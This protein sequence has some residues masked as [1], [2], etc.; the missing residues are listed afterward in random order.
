L[1]PHSEIRIPHSKRVTISRTGMCRAIVG[2]GSAIS[3]WLEAPDEVEL[4]REDVHVWSAALDVGPEFVGACAAI[5]IEDERERAA[6][7]RF[8][9]DRTHFIVARATLRKILA[10]YL[11][12]EPT[13][14]AFAAGAYGKPALATAGQGWLQFNLSHSGG[15]A[16]Y[17]L[18]RRRAV[19]V[20]IEAVRPMADAERVAERFF[21][22]CEREDLR[23]LPK[24]DRTEGFF[25]CWTRKEAYIKAIGHGLSMPL[26]KFDVSLEPGDAARLIRVVDQPDE[27]KRWALRE[28][29]P[30]PGLIGA[31]VVEQPCARVSCWKFKP[32]HGA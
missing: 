29:R 27:A 30:G 26:D 4:G 24:A 12:T 23:R 25:R 21:S 11:A 9:K 1:I 31:L 19:G 3:G 6:R 15:W 16:L 13:A 5:L 20:D 14:I 28:L 22:L 18:A 2:E 7:F 32:P 17:A 10:R 8:E